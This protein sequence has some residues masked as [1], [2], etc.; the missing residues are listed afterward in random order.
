MSEIKQPTIAEVVAFLQETY[1]RAER[2]DAATSMGMVLSA[3]AEPAAGDLGERLPG[4]VACWA[5]ET[6]A[7]RAAND[8]LDDRAM[9]LLERSVAGRML[10]R[11]D[12]RPD[13]ADA[14]KLWSAIATWLRAR[15]ADCVRTGADELVTRGY[16]ARAMVYEGE[17][18][19][20]NT[21]V[22]PT[23]DTA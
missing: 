14:V 19:F 10:C 20:L 2:H 16:A 11:G 6:L 23:E 5:W 22:Q 3:L 8:G 4:Y 17:R 13:P 12:D 21:L 18:D 7:E 9:L 1:A 15:E